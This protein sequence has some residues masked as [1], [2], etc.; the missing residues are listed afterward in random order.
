M[1]SYFVCNASRLFVLSSWHLVEWGEGRRRGEGGEEAGVGGALGG[2]TTLA[3][4]TCACHFA[5]SELGN[6]SL[7]FLEAFSN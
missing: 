7:T 6:G 5:T 4:Q 3:S 2:I 1:V